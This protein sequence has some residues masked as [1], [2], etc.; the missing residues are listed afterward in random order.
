MQS[1]TY[2]YK[3]LLCRFDDR[4][5]DSLCTSVHNPVYSIK[6]LHIKSSEQGVLW[7][8]MYKTTANKFRT[9]SRF[10]WCISTVD[11]GAALL[12]IFGSQIVFLT[13]L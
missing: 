12:L 13:I 1:F 7:Q 9:D 11:G 4:F 2:T 3:H 5:N 8:L 10:S 6:A